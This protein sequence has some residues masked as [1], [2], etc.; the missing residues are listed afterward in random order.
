M[1]FNKSDVEYIYVIGGY[2]KL[3]QNNM[4]I[5]T[6]KELEK[7]IDDSEIA[8]IQLINDAST[9][10]R[11]TNKLIVSDLTSKA[12]SKLTGDI[13]ILQN[14]DLPD[15]EH[16]RLKEKI[17]QSSNKIGAYLRQHFGED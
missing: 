11:D 13:M 16:D 9:N 6:A 7:Y 14:L 1:L 10:Q 2:D 15:D 4:G 17:K 8:F 12:A 5:E 3:N